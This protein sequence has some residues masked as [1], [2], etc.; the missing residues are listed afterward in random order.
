MARTMDGRKTPS[1]EYVAEPRQRTRSDLLDAR[2]LARRYDP[3]FDLDG[4]GTVCFTMPL[5]RVMVW[6]YR[7]RAC[8]SGVHVAVRG[9][10][11]GR[12]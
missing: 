1:L 12:T 5:V 3:S 11:E 8:R 7:P 2:R 6:C 10:S 4:D 9:G